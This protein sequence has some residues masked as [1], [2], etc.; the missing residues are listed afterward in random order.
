MKTFLQLAFGSIVLILVFSAFSCSNPTDSSAATTVAAT[1]T[2]TADSP[3]GTPVGSIYTAPSSSILAYQNAFSGIATASANISSNTTAWKSA[4]SSLVSRTAGSLL[5]YTYDSGT[6]LTA[7]ISSQTDGTT[8]TQAFKETFS[9]Y[10][11]SGTVYNGTIT[12]SSVLDS[13]TSTLTA[14]YKGLLVLTGTNAATVG[15]DLKFSTSSTSS[16]STGKVSV[17]GITYS[18]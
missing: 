16:S 7:S 17:N 11:V 9:A 8:T 13:S 5:K 1:P 15:F 4:S 6:G 10:T 3:T 18:L 14:S 2:L 12:Y